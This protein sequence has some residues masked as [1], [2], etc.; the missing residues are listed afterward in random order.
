MHGVCHFDIPTKNPAKL[1]PFYRDV[2]GWKTEVSRGYHMFRPPNSITG[3]LDTKVEA[4]VIYVEVADIPAKL[5]EV[6]RAGGKVVTPK[7][8]I[9]E[10]FGYYAYFTDTEGNVIGL[11]SQH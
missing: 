10:G 2:F 8:H 3:G 11:W 5:T 9:G 7:T 6:E 1:A 4:P